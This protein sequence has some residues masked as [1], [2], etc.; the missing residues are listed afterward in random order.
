MLAK[1]HYD[2]HLSHIYSW[3]QGDF[4]EQ[5]AEQKRIFGMFDLLPS[6]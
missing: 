2:N 4:S 6:P 1:E 3:M 5:V